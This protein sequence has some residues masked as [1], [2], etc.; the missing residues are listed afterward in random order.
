MTVKCSLL[1]GLIA[2]LYGW[3]TFTLSSFQTRLWS[4]DCQE[5]N[6]GSWSIG[7]VVYLAHSQPH[8][9]RDVDDDCYVGDQGLAA[10]G[11]CCKH[12]EDLNLRFGE[13][14]VELAMSMKNSLKSLGVVACAKI[15]NISMEALGT[16]CRSLETLPLDFE[17][18]NNKGVLVVAEGRPHLKVLKLRCINFTGDALKA[19]GTRCFS[20]E[21][22]SL[23]SFRR[24]KK[25]KNLTA[26]NC[27][28]LSNICLEA[29]A[30]G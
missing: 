10:V 2:T 24:C 22:L 12:L 7:I 15:T 23:Y 17:Y 9:N 26:S 4:S 8:R 29:I 1:L 6:E 27:Y 18:I 16:H 19:F 14:L 5:D 21:L 25:L 30:G 13:G 28:L 11:R 3:V 20:L